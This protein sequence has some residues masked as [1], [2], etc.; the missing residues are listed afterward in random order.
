MNEW[1][2]KLQRNHPVKYSAIGEGNT[3]EIH[4]IL[5]L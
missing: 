5:G 1:I 2:K 3:N 4:E